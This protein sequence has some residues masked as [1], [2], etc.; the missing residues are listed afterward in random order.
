[1]KKGTKITYWLF[2]SFL[3]FTLIHNLMSAVWGIEEATFFLLA[4]LSLAG[5]L[6]SVI[7]NLIA[8]LC[9]GKPNDIWKLGYLGI[10]G[11]LG[12]A[13]WPPRMIPFALFILF[14]F[15]LAKNKRELPQQEEDYNSGVIEL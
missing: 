14:L 9:K 7:V 5:F 4:L 2:F 6:I 8:F 3:L 13:S 15:F 1:M 12:F 11:I 10:F